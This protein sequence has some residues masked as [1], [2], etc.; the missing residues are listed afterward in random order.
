MI[1][2]GTHTEW[3]EIRCADCN[4]KILITMDTLRRVAD[5]IV[6]VL[7][8]PCSSIRIMEGWHP[9]CSC[10]LCEGRSVAL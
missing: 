2:V 1:E 6:F 8:D 5:G 4:R 7:C 3:C 10:D 9:F